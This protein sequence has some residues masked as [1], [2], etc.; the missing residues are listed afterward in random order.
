MVLR[1]ELVAEAAQ[2]QVAQ[3]LHGLDQ[4]GAR[5]AGACGAQAFDEYARVNLAGIAVVV[6]RFVVALHGG[7]EVARERNGGLGG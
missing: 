1:A 3:A 6:R 7:L 2:V 5:D 4:A